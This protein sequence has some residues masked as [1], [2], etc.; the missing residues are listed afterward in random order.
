MHPIPFDSD[1]LII[2]LI[3]QLLNLIRIKPFLV[4]INFK[5]IFKAFFWWV[6]CVDP[7]FG[8]NKDLAERIKASEEF[9]DLNLIAFI[10]SY[11]ASKP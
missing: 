10:K 3:P 9:T 5:E 8:R 6:F 7:F 2:F 11:N 1:K 4:I